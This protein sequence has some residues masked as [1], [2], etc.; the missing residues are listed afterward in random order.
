MSSIVL[1]PSI[2]LYVGVV[3][4]QPEPGV[5]AGQVFCAESFACRGAA[6]ATSGSDDSRDENPHAI[7]MGRWR[8]GLWDFCAH[9]CC[10]PLCCLTY[11]VRPLALGQV[12]HR[13]KLTP[14]G[15]RMPTEDVNANTTISPFS[16]MAALVLFLY[17]FNNAFPFIIPPPPP[18]NNNGEVPADTSEVPIPWSSIVSLCFYIFV[19]VAASVYILWMTCKTRNYLRRVYAIPSCCSRNNNNNN[20][21]GDGCGGWWEDACCS[22]WCGCCVVAQMARHTVD[23]RNANAACCTEDGLGEAHDNY[24]Y[25]NNAA[26]AMRGRRTHGKQPLAIHA[27]IV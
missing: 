6:T 7:P 11:C 21:G 16:V 10:H 20:N 18:S 23:Y 19:N 5:C 3:V 26:A 14:C 8:D 17:I 4:V 15:N 24:S 13:L 12:M 9:G 2:D 1:F 25:H 27:D 22:F